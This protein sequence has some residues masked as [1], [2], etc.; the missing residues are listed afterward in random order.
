MM[1]LGYTLQEV[2]GKGELLREQMEKME[3]NRIMEGIEDGWME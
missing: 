1:R 3:S 2:N